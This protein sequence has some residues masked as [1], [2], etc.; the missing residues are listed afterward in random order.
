M[1]II[2]G[3]SLFSY[4]QGVV[5]AVRYSQTMNLGTA[6]ST[7]MGSAFTALGG[8]FSAIS[9]NPAG[10]GVYKKSEFTFSPSFNF[11]SSYSNYINSSTSDFNVNLR[12]N[13]IGWVGAYG[14]GATSGLKNIN[15]A[16]GYNR[17]GDY[18]NDFRIK[19][20]NPEHSI[21]DYFNDNIGSDDPER[22][23]SYYER[24]AFDTYIIDTVSYGNYI[25]NTPPGDLD[26]VET[27]SIKGGK[28][29]WFAAIGFNISDKLYFGFNL[30]MEK[31]DYEMS[32]IFKEMNRNNGSFVDLTFSKSLWING[33][34]FKSSL[35][36]IGKPIEELRI[37][38][39]L[40]LPT[41]Y[42]FTEELMTSMTSNYVT[43]VVKPTDINGRY[44]PRRE[45]NY[46]FITP[47]KLSVGVAGIIEKMAILSIDYDILNYEIMKFYGGDND[48]S[49]V[50][51]EIR[52]ITR[53]SS[54]VRVGAEVRFDE[55]YLRGGANFIQSPYKEKIGDLAV[56]NLHYNTFSSAYSGGIGYRSNDFFIDF[57]GIYALSREYDHL[58]NLSSNYMSA[59]SLQN[60]PVELNQMNFRFITT[61]GFRF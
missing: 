61:I 55:L 46:S 9:I 23:D 27:R 17:N 14:T 12:S 15:F 40:Q 32:S 35:G 4:S 10:L 36:V 11:N 28:K 39:S 2:S 13:Q 51:E 41:F 42:R 3:L 6:R 45:Y 34:G 22:L 1:V 38:M 48:Y 20:I 53:I 43:E 19:G 58:Y 29:E 21:G 18:S 30:G 56:D 57:S 5:D 54:N 49:N 47:V 52:E 31:L 33:S 16:I 37:G 8:D 24:L 50:N 59:N 44:L 25:V 7:A 60:Y 26:Q